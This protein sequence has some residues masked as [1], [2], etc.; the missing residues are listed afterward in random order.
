MPPHAPPSV[1]RLPRLSAAISAGSWRSCSRSLLG[2][3]PRAQAR[4][5][6][7]NELKEFSAAVRESA[8]SVAV[9][10]RLRSFLANDP[11]SA[12]ALFARRALV[13]ALISSHAPGKDI[14]Q[15]S[16]HQGREGAGSSNRL[17]LYLTVADGLS[18]RGIEPTSAVLYANRA[19]AVVPADRSTPR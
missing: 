6:T 3:G 13:A 14:V 16:S 5:L 17:L 12:Y 2:A 15:A 11:D 1:L 10:P 9:I 19:L 18:F 8:A 7:L 4:N